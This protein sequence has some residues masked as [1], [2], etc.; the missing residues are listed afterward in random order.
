MDMICIID[1]KTKSVIY[2]DEDV[3]EQLDLKPFQRVSRK[4][5]LKAVGLTASAIAKKSEPVSDTY[6]LQSDCND[7]NK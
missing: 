6:K 3:A 5:V 1:K 4:I 2:V 7:A